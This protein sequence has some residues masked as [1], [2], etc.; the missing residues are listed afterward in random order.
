VQHENLLS[1]VFRQAAKA[2]N[3]FVSG[4]NPVWSVD[5][6]KPSL[7]SRENSV[8]SD[9]FE[10]V[11]IV[12]TKHPSSHTSLREFIYNSP[13]NTMSNHGKEPGH[14]TPTLDKHSSIIMSAQQEDT[15][16]N[17]SGF[18]PHNTTAQD[19][20]ND[21]TESVTTAQVPDVPVTDGPQY[22]QMQLAKVTK[23]T[24]D[25]MTTV[26]EGDGQGTN[27][28]HDGRHDAAIPG[29]DVEAVAVVKK[30]ETDEEEDGDASVPG[31]GEADTGAV[32][33]KDEE[34][35]E[36]IKE[37]IKEED[38][39]DGDV[40]ADRVSTYLPSLPFIPVSRPTLYTAYLTDT[41]TASDH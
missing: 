26:A 15:T 16:M 21:Q 28:G 23:L 8:R 33:A 36:E 12:F 29:E 40:A 10:C 13:S 19:P 14:T 3:T 6:V 20:T 35:K 18:A 2:V 37:E 34:A 9:S 24:E 1:I 22:V 4:A 11:S 39:G 27:E 31:E 5:G 38:E 25:R 41:T 32:D 17:A 7:P 30:E